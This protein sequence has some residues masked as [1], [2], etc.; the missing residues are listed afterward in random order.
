MVKSTIIIFLKDHT[1]KRISLMDV[2]NDVIILTWSQKFLRVWS[3]TCALK[4]KKVS[5]KYTFYKK[6]IDWA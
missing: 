3:R 5:M 6:A 2:I 1:D 4:R